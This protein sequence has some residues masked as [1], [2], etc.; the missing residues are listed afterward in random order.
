M[1]KVKKC[2]RCKKLQRLNSF[3]KHKLRKDGLHGTCKRCRSLYSR[4]NKGRSQRRKYQATPKYKT[5]ELLHKYGITF[6]QKE[7]MFKLQ[8]GICA[9]CP[10]Q[11]KSVS[12]AQVD[13]CHRTGKV[14][15][16]LCGPCNRLLGH[17]EKNNSIFQ[18]FD[19]Y[20]K[21]NG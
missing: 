20:V 6:Q 4:S 2:S 10:R 18:L 11:F 17:Y 7:Q 12:S 19:K 8:N 1:A 5:L 16:L 21:E 14:R 9:I 15:K 13:H 3:H